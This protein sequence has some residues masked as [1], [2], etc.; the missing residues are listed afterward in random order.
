LIAINYLFSINDL[1]LLTILVLQIKWFVAISGKIIFYFISRERGNVGRVKLE[2]KEKY[3][4]NFELQV[5]GIDVNYGGHVG[6]SQMASIAH[7]GTIQTLRN[8][9]LSELDLGDGKTGYIFSD[10]V[11]NFKSE[12]FLGDLL[13]ISSVI[14]DIN[15]KSFRIYH[16]ISKGDRVVALV[17]AGAVAFNFFERKVGVVPEVFIEKINEFQK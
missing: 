12:A 16:K 5:R 15:E 2:E 6:N 8:L 4:F 3:F 10:M 17:E 9:K 11:L 1:I 13:T 14:D 7:E